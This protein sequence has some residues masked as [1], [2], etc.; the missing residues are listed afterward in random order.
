MNDAIQNYEKFNALLK[1]FKSM[2]NLTD[3]ETYVLK[4]LILDFGMYTE[5]RTSVIMEQI[6]DEAITSCTYTLEYIAK[7]MKESH[8]Q[9]NL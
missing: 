7:T 2:V 6:F 1:D 8:K 5:I 9:P 3:I 4:H